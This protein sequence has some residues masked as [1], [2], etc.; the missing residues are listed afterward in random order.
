M[1][2]KSTVGISVFWSASIFAVDCASAFVCQVF[3]PNQLAV[4]IVFCHRAYYNDTSCPLAFIVIL[5]N[6]PSLVISLMSTFA[7]AGSI[8]FYK[9][10][11]IFPYSHQDYVNFFPISLECKTSANIAAIT[12]TTIIATIVSYFCSIFRNIFFTLAVFF[13]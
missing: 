10:F 8:V 6:S 3:D 5:Y 4:E 7:S 11:E 13:T 9:C 2:N 1:T 12:I